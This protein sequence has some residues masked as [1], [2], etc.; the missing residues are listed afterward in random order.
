VSE[1]RGRIGAGGTLDIPVTLT[2]T[3]SNGGLNHLIATV[4]DRDGSGRAG[5][6]STEW[7]IALGEVVAVPTPP[8][9]VFALHRAAPNPFGARTALTFSLA[10]REPA[11]LR[12]YDVRGALVKT[13]ADGI[14]E[15]GLHRVEWDG[16][17]ARGHRKR[18]GIYYAQL[19]SGEQVRTLRVA[20]VR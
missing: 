3:G 10:N 8:P 9:A 7:V 17:D 6:L 14:L 20:M 5:P 15:P 16:T 13:L 19:R 11:S 4:L 1:T 2:H 12:I 18:A